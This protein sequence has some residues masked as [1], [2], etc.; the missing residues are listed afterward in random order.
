MSDPAYNLIPAA[1]SSSPSSC[2]PASPSSSRPHSPSTSTSMSSPRQPIKLRLMLA[3]QPKLWKPKG[4]KRSREEDPI[5]GTSWSGFAAQTQ[6]TVEADVQ[7]RTTVGIKFKKQK[8]HEG[9]HN[10]TCLDSDEGEK[11]TAQPSSSGRMFSF[12]FAVGQHNPAST[13]S[14]A[15]ASSSKMTMDVDTRSSTPTNETPVAKRPR[16]HSTSS[17]IVGLLV[18]DDEAPA[19]PVDVTT[20]PTLSIAS[21]SSAPS[22]TNNNSKNSHPPHV[23]SPLASSRITGVPLELPPAFASS[24]SGVKASSSGAAGSSATT[25]E[26]EMLTPGPSPLV[27]G[28]PMTQLAK[29]RAK[30]L[31]EVEALGTE[32]NNV[33]KLG[34]GRA[35]GR[36]VSGSRG[37]SR[38]S[39]DV[40]KKGSEASQ[41]EAKSKDMEIDG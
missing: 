26:I 39:V 18:S 16:S 5:D 31:A 14:N 38:L 32:M 7:E 17:S 21:L 9:T 34:Y 30:F 41:Q 27:E 25:R 11:Y 29:A 13:Q 8:H 24:G 1:S 28:N 12:N 2:M 37:P 15:V 10:R 36:G 20:S 23:P 4:Q 3:A 6:G 22:S 33:F 19:S 40:A 35:L